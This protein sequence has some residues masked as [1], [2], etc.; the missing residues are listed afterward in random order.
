MKKIIFSL[1][2]AGICATAVRGGETNALSRARAVTAGYPKL[3]FF[4]NCEAF[5][6]S[7][8]V[9]AFE[10]CVGNRTVGLIGKP[11]TE[12]LERRTPAV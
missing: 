6:E 5:M 3:L 7:N 10:R 8:T 12:E 4:R 9:A 2:V 1:A 11:F